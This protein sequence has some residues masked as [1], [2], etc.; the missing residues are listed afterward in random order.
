MITTR[1][2]ISMYEK[3]QD[4]ATKIAA[5]LKANPDARLLD[6]K[7]TPI[8]QYNQVYVLLILEVPDDYTD[9]KGA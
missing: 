3:D 2:C 5:Y 7:M 6:V 8:C 9:K 4:P 1:G